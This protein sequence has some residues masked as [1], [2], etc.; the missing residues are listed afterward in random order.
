MT[1]FVRK[2]CLQFSLSKSKRGRR[3]ST[4]ETLGGF[5]YICTLTKSWPAG[6]KSSH[7]LI[8]AKSRE[9]PRTAAEQ[10]LPVNLALPFWPPLSQSNIDFCHF[11][12]TKNFFFL[13]FSTVTL[14]FK[15]KNYLFILIKKGPKNEVKP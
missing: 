15:S 2:E 8:A 12:L 10:A 5:L 6:N 1:C 13:S 14:L 9:L 4:T 3:T 11:I 7:C